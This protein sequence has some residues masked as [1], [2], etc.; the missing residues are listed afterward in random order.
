ME[1]FFINIKVETLILHLYVFNPEGAGWALSGIWP[2]IINILREV[3]VKLMQDEKYI[4][5]KTLIFLMTPVSVSGGV[6]RSTISPPW[7]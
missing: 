6:M 1:I 3:M 2:D 5:F 7:V 4:I